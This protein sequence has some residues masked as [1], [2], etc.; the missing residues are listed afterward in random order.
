[1]SHRPVATPHHRR[2]N[3]IHPRRPAHAHGRGQAKWLVLTYMAGDND[4]EGAAIDDIKQMETVGSRPGEVEVVVQV[5]RAAGYDTPTGGWHGTRRY[6]ITRGA[7]RRRIRSRPLAD[8]GETN[9]GVPRSSKSSSTL[10]S[11]ASP[12]RPAR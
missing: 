1:M 6:Y 12:R 9:T 4:L 7:D 10:G 2:A 3:P 11:A 8:L 5:D